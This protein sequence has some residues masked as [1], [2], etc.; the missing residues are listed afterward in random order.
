MITLVKILGE[1]LYNWTDKNLHFLIG[2]AVIGI[3][4]SIIEH[5]G[6]MGFDLRWFL[7]FELP[8]YLFLLWAIFKII[9][10]FKNNGSKK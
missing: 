1:K 3:V 9:G 2:I 10:I 4:C 8:L 6:T 7:G 5:Y